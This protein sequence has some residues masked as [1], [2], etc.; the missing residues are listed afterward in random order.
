MLVTKRDSQLSYKLGEPHQ[1]QKSG[2]F[3]YRP[4]IPCVCNAGSAKEASHDKPAHAP[5]LFIVAE[6]GRLLEMAIRKLQ[7][8]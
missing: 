8:K 1:D 2:L 4:Q 7:L 6:T 5:L 3:M